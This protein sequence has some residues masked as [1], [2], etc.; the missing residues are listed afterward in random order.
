M[1]KNLSRIAVALMLVLLVSAFAGAQSMNFPT[2]SNLSLRRSSSHETW[3]TVLIVGA[4]LLVI[5]IADDDSTLAILGGAGVLVA[6]SETNGNAFQYR[7]VGRSFD[8]VKSGALSFG[9]NPFGS[10]GLTQDFKL[11]RPSAVLQATF[12]F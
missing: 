6:L 8:L 9:V 7:S 3:H 2:S 10:M 1:M 12:K 5:G 4:V 11:S